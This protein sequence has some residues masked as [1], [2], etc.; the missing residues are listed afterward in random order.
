[1]KKLYQRTTQGLIATTPCYRLP[2]C[3]IPQIFSLAKANPEAVI[4]QLRRGKIY[5]PLHAFRKGEFCQRALRLPNNVPA[6]AF[7]WRC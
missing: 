5:S 3:S 1:M 4:R 7:R 6:A 2:Q